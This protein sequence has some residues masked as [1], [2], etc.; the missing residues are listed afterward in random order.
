MEDA[1]TSLAGISRRRQFLCVTLRE[2][3]RASGAEIG[4]GYTEAVGNADSS[5]EDERHRKRVPESAS[6]E[7]PVNKWRQGFVRRDNLLL[8]LCVILA[9]VSA[10]VLVAGSHL[11]DGIGYQKIGKF[12]EADRE[13]RA[14]ITELSTAGNQRDLVQAM[15]AE[16]WISVSLGNVRMPSSKRLTPSNY[17]VCCT[18]RDILRMI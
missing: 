2:N 17:V 18:M 12:K 8:R 11:D 15:S 4:G 9:M 10:R 3:L 13:L 5:Q 14:A 6:C 1:G 7:K 16:S